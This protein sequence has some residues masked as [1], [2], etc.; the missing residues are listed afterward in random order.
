MKLRGQHMGTP[1]RIAI[2]MGDPAGI[3]PEIIAKL[4]ARGS[5]DAGTAI[6]LSSF[7]SMPV[8]R[9]IEGNQKLFFQIYWSGDRD[10]ILHRA[11]R[12]YSAGAR[13]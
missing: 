8:E 4:Y 11:Q 7:A 2:T 6:G 13:A 5:R 12:A 10:T 1:P 9:V 3:G